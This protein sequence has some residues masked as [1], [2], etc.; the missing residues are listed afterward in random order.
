[1]VVY[2]MDRDSFDPCE[3]CEQDPETCECDPEECVAERFQEYCE[4]SRDAY[5]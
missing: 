2:L 4:G 1:M 3:D 5:E